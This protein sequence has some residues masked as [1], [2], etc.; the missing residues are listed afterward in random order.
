MSTSANETL[1]RR[2]I[3]AIWNHGDLVSFAKTS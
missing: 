3:E 1:V 2:A